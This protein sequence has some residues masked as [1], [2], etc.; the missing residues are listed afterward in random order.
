MTSTPTARM[1]IRGEL[2]FRQGSRAP[3]DGPRRRWPSSSTPTAPADTT[4][5]SSTHG[6]SRAPSP[7]A[8]ASGSST[9][10]TRT[11]PSQGAGVVPQE[12]GADRQGV[13]TAH[14]AAGAA[15]Q[16]SPLDGGLGRRDGRSGRRVPA[17]V[18]PPSTPSSRTGAGRIESRRA[19]SSRP[20][21]LCRPRG[22]ASAM[23]RPARRSRRARPRRRA[24]PRGTG[25]PRREV[26]R[27]LRPLGPRRHGAA[28]TRRP[29]PGDLA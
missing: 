15:P 2:G 4:S 14:P 6:R 10:G 26:L 17:T 7:T 25:L 5:G 1:T 27:G 19:R 12:P 8:S 28:A 24:G 11:R 9:A 18:P 16:A 29:G 23:Q 13:R 20:I 22:L 21:S 3:G